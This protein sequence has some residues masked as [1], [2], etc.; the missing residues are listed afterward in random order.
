MIN[1]HPIFFLPFWVFWCDRL[2]VTGAC[3]WQLPPTLYLSVTF[4]MTECSQIEIEMRIFYP[5]VITILTIAR[6]PRPFYFLISCYSHYAKNAFWFKPTTFGT[7]LTVWPEKITNLRFRQTLKSICVISVEKG[8]THYACASWTTRSLQYSFFK[9]L[10][11]LHKT[12]FT[13]SH[14]IKRKNVCRPSK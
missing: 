3:G 12:Q 13:S 9:I 14:S 11:T 10:V 8:K 4:E 5:G 1:D 2:V 7:H 6:Q